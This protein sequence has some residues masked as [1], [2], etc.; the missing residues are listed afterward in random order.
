MAFGADSM[1]A[2]FSGLSSIGS[3][4]AARQQAESDRQWQEYNNKMTRI[5]DAQNQNAITANANMRREREH[6]QLMQIDKS[7]KAT[8][9]TA[10]VSAAASGTIGRSVNMVLFDINRNAAN[11]RGALAKDSDMQDVQDQNQRMQSAM[12]SE[13]ELDLRYIT[14]PSPASLLLGLG[15]AGLNLQKSL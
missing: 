4:I 2:I 5:Q 9:A 7:E 6:A 8:L 1:S 13:M 11:A 15:T 3:Y 10:E 14:N 12:Q